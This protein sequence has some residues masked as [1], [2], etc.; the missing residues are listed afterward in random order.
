MTYNAL[1]PPP[2]VFGLPDQFSAWRPHQDAAALAVFE[3]AA[4]AIA[5]VA[6]TGFGKSPLAIAV[7]ALMRAVNPD[8]RTAYL[9]VTKGLQEQVARDFAPMGMVQIKG[10]SNYECIKIRDDEGRSEGCDSGPCHAGTEC[11]LKASGCLYYD[12]FR[13]AKWNALVTPNYDYWLNVYRGAEKDDDGLGRFDLL[14][15][16][17]AHSAPDKL[18]DFLAT[19]IKGEVVEGVL[20]SRLPPR[21]A[22]LPGWGDWAG[23]HRQIAQQRYDYL[24]AAA[25]DHSHRLSFD[26]RRDLK[27]LR[28]LLT[29]LSTIEIAADDAPNWI[30]DR[31][32]GNDAKFDPI[33]PG[34]YLGQLTQGIS[35][36]LLLS[37]TIRPKT[38]ELLGFK[39]ADTDFL[40]Y[41]SSFPV[42]RRPVIAIPTIA[43]R[44][45]MSM[46]QEREWIRRVDQIIAR[47]L[48]RKGIVHAVSYARAKLLV[49][50]SAHRQFM[51]INEPRTTQ[52]TI[53][54]FKAAPAPAIL[55]SPSIG[56]GF[57]F[58]YTDAEYCVIVKI[59]F[60]SVKENPVLKARS[61]SDKS[62]LNYCAMQAVVQMAGRGMRAVD[63][64]CETFILD[65]QWNNWFLRDAQQFA[66]RW[67][68]DALRTSGYI[69]PPPPKLEVEE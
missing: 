8:T 37:A 1:L 44:Y 12:H 47:R 67:F 22:D 3:S 4:P 29:Q 11:E 17:E 48:D 2:D 68:L 41:P 7:H 6:P 43:M 20:N 36:T 60:A 15:L 40:E 34:K 65:A 21:D 23:K 69:P 24:A 42:E 39:R 31:S 19:E 64:Q 18:C 5:V 38:L 16:D 58:P 56:T 55:V 52:T 26:E 27:L 28:G 57:D 50:N 33:W 25:K 9:T 54:K 51:M 46:D 53:A 10:Q 62:Y 49:E 30:V 63:D 45:G 35:K 61:E 32:R 66:P 59:P 13:R 14:I